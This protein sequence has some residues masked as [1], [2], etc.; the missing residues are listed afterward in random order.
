M[1]LPGFPFILC[2]ALLLAQACKP[3]EDRH[4]RVVRF[5]M[6]A[7]CSVTVPGAGKE[8]DAAIA[9]AFA[10]MEAVDRR[11]TIHSNAAPLARFNARRGPLEDPELIAVISRTLEM[12][13][14]SDG[15]FDPTVTPLVE[16]WGFYGSN[17]GRVPSALEIREALASAGWRKIEVRDGRVVKR[18]PRVRLD[19]GGA[20]KG[21]AVGEAMKALREHGIK[22]ALIDAGG[23]I[24]AIGKNKGKAWRV[25]IQDPRGEGLVDLVEVVGTSLS[26][27]GDYQRTF[28]SGGARYHHLIDPATGRPAESGLWSAT[29]IHPDALLAD[30][31][32]TAVFILGKERGLALIARTSGARAV[33][34]TSTGKVVRSW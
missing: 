15:A 19:L 23:A 18:D 5:L 3:R 22:S 2:A 25:G 9:A 27:S 4:T 31:L 28:I 6:D 32:S 29:V 16:A 11:F 26:T 17:A 8:I 13:R 10:R 30:M 1:N 14:L 24:Y 12:A 21:Y 34:V 20:A 7:P 33:L